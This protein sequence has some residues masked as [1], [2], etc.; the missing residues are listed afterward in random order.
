MFGLKTKHLTDYHKDKEFENEGVYNAGYLGYAEPEMNMEEALKQGIKIKFFAWI[1]IG[2][3][4]T[5]WEKIRGRW[6]KER[7]GTDY[8]KCG[9]CLDGDEPKCKNKDCLVNRRWKK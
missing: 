2:D 8:R 3:R 4:N 9:D 7:D 5:L 6:I 1:P